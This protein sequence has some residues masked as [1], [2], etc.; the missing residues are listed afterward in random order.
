MFLLEL[1]GGRDIS[2]PK[3][4]ELA[5][6]AFSDKAAG[7]LQEWPVLPEFVRTPQGVDP[8]KHR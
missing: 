4:E 8:S 7:L 1:E 2:C 5:G 3:S 6:A